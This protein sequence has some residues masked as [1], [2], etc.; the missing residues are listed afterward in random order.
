MKTT[1]RCPVCAGAIDL[2][3]SSS[4]RRRGPGVVR[5]NIFVSAAVAAAGWSATDATET[6]TF[7]RRRFDKRCLVITVVARKRPLTV[8]IVFY[9]RRYVVLCT[10]NPTTTV[11]VFYVVILLIRVMCTRSPCKRFSFFVHRRRVL[12]C[13]ACSF[14]GLFKSVTGNIV[15]I[16]HARPLEFSTSRRA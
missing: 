4:C 13:S 12:F 2:V 11:V 6:R 9:F 8:I 3:A 7:T 10:H 14:F 5:R 1:S 15:T 16:C